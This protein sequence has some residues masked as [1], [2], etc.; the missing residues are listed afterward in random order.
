M[1]TADHPDWNYRILADIDF[2]QGVVRGTD[3][4]G[5]AIT[6]PASCYVASKLTG[7]LEGGKWVLDA[8]GNW[9]QLTDENGNVE[10]YTLT[11]LSDLAVANNPRGKGVQTN[12]LQNYGAV[13]SQFAGTMS[14]LVIKEHDPW[15]TAGSYQRTWQ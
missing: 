7:R 5:Q 11:G 15:C 3:D 14:N 12:R 8:A 13:F 4:N 10:C 2:S 9:Q 6:G 1:A